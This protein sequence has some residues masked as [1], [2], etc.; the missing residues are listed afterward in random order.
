MLVI[1]RQAKASFCCQP[2]L[3]AFELPR[4]FPNIFC[5]NYCLTSG[6][7]SQ[8]ATHHVLF[9]IRFVFIKRKIV[10][11]Q[12]DLPL[13]RKNVIVAVRYVLSTAKFYLTTYFT[14]GTP[15]NCLFLPLPEK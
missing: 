14:I 13:E 2:N 3:A 5:T 4:T 7:I 11:L 6:A 1:Y 8:T 10:S 15:C 12:Y 9:V